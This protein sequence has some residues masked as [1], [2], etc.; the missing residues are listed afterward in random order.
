MTGRRGVLLC[1]FLAGA[2]LPWLPTG[3][4]AE[5][6]AEA[7]EAAGGWLRQLSLSGAGGNLL[8]WA[9]ALLLS[10]LPLLLLVLPRGR[11]TLRWEDA[12]LPLAALTLFALIYGAVN[13]GWMTSPFSD[14]W[15]LA[16]LGA[17]L[18]TALAAW[19]IL[20]LLRGLEGSSP[21]KLSQVLQVLLLA[22]GALLIL[23][24]AARGS[25]NLL[26]IWDQGDVAAARQWA[27]QELGFQGSFPT[28]AADR[29]FLSALAVLDVVPSLLGAWVLALAAGLTAALGTDPFAPESVMECERVARRCR[30]AL[31]AALLLA[32]GENLLQLALYTRL[33][34]LHFSLN[35]PLIPLILSAALY[36]L[37]RCIQRGRELQEDNESII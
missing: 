23:A 6:L 3:Q 21:K 20:Q 2:L 17:A 31:T 25:G 9:I 13:P 5:A 36:L 16:A 4:G 37:C 11:G 35:L 1:A 12:L 26:D 19:L 15:A 29:A 14:G 24:A 30:L 33:S 22:C 32:L 34:T 18:G 10:A 8:A 27:E 28:Q 7:V